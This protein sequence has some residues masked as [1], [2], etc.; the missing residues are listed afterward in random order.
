MEGYGPDLAR[1]STVRRLR[2]DPQ[3]STVI[4][5]ARSNVGPIAWEGTGPTGEFAFAADGDAIAGAPAPHGWLE[6]PLES[7]KSGNSI[8]DTE[9]LR[10]VDAHRHPVARVELDELGTPDADGAYEASGHLTFH[11]VARRL[12]GRLELDLRADGSVLA[13]GTQDVD[14][15][16]FGLPAPTMLVLQVSPV[17]RV[18][19]VVEGEPVG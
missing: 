7:L 5:E 1:G 15:R 12:S 14:I 3:H 2:I 18:Y 9:L 13:T 17:V 4:V 19:L 6:L 10:R 16:D 8:Y 11:G